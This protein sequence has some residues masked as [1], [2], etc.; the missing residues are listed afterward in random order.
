MLNVCMFTLGNPHRYVRSLCSTLAEV[1]PSRGVGAFLV[2]GPAPE[3][4]EPLSCRVEVGYLAAPGPR[5]RL[6]EPAPLAWLQA[7]L[8]P[9]PST[10][11]FA[12]APWPTY[13]HR[14]LSTEQFPGVRGWAVPGSPP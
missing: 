9:A 5:S 11:F 1:G 7:A 10:H 2:T 4:A 12:M 13:R 14:A 8:P 6:H 3:L